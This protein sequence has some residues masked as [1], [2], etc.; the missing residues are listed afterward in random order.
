MLAKNGGQM[1]S[2]IG[3]IA[4]ATVV[5]G[6]LVTVAD[7]AQ[8]TL[9]YDQNVTPDVIF[10]SGN[11]NGS[12]T[13]DRENGIE[14]G[15]RGKLRYPTP[16]NTFNSNGDGTYSFD[17]GGPD[18]A[19]PE[20]S[21]EWSINTNFDGSGG[22]FTGLTFFL[23]LDYDPGLGVDSHGFDLINAGVFDHDFGTNATGNGGGMHT[24]D[25]G[26]YAGYLSSKNVAQ[27]SWNYAFFPLAAFDS[28]QDGRYTISLSAFRSE[29]LLAS[30]S[31]DIIVGKGA[32]KVPEPAS[33]G[34]VGVGL[35]G[36]GFARRRKAA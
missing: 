25:P 20:W 8:A 35:L 15:L 9:L 23:S 10:G 18:A 2:K 36:I 28:M 5:L 29:D 32:S 13:V 27:N 12:F 16:E 19:H 14:L 22:T 30:T 34:L 6:G 4:A 11:D 17:T 24:S 3:R 31:I 1:M 26:T 33:L 21:Y 7:S